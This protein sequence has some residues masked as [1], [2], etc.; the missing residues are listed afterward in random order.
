MLKF[1]EKN[2]GTFCL[3]PQEYFTEFQDK[4]STV[5]ILHKILLKKKTYLKRR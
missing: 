3:D 5:H 2:P 4:I 1:E